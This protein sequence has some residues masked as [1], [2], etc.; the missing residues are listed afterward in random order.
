M[1]VCATGKN[2]VNEMTRY[3][4]NSD[5]VDR[6][7]FDTVAR[8]CGAEAARAAHSS[9]DDY[10]PDSIKP[11]K[12]AEIAWWETEFQDYSKDEDW[13]ID[14]LDEAKIRWIDAW[15]RGFRHELELEEKLGS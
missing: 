2:Q 3:F 11:E 14:D 6:I 1:D 7:R 12:L 10:D 8:E 5:Q 13:Y 9:K 15:S 4:L